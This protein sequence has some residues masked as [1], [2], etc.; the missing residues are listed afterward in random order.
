LRISVH[1]QDRSEGF[2]VHALR[3]ADKAPFE[4]A[5]VVGVQLDNLV[6]VVEDP[7]ID[8]LGNLLA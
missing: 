5:D 7:L 3:P 4:L 8:Q 2:A 6:M 1:P